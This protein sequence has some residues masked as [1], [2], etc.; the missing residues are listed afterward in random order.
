MNEDIERRLRQ[1]RPRGAAPK[2]R[3]LVLTAVANELGAGAPLPSTWRIRPGFVVAAA[4]FASLALNYWVTDRLDRW[5]SI[6]LG[7]P[8]V[9]RQTA[10]IT[11]DIASITDTYTGEWAYRR[12]AAAQPARD[13]A[14]QYAV[15]LQQMN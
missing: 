8:Q 5:L 10:A 13:E 12:L 7:T 14:R 15:R 11:A 3:S 9:D 6:A 2:L 4:L 1:V